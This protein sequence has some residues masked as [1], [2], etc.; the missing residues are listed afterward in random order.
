MAFT[1]LVSILNVG[2]SAGLFNPDSFLGSFFSGFSGLA[3]LLLAIGDSSFLSVPEGNDVLI[4]ILSTGGT[5]SNMAYYVSMTVVGS[6]IGC[7]ILYTVGRKGGRAILRK[8][9]SAS[10]IERA[11]NLYSRHG[12][13]A[14]LISSIMPPPLPFKIFVLS[15]GVFGLSPLR[16]FS[17]IAIG[18]SIRYSMWGI[19]AVLYGNAVKLFLLNN[20]ETVGIIICVLIILVI[21]GTVFFYLR[22]KKRGEKNEFDSI[23][24][25]KS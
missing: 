2:N 9:F 5:W 22:N 19:L 17:A 3:V 8:R 23:N 6:V 7:L 16:F 21:A 12:L 18:R 14:V 10:K 24:G 25:G 11:E 15:A 4:V 13:A 1:L 20:I